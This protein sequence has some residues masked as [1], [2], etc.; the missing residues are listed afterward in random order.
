MRSLILLSS[1]ALLL[2]CTNG[3]SL[4]LDPDRGRLVEPGIT[5][6]LDKS[7]YRIGEIVTVRMTN[8]SPRDYGY[9]LCGRRYDRRVASGWVEM[10]EE[11]RMCTAHID[12]LPAGATRT[13]QTDLHSDATPGTYRLVVTFLATSG[14]GD[15]SRVVGVGPSFTIR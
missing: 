8:S 5:I 10:P 13:G 4:V 14:T 3:A 11:L 2:G 7:E 1:A 6:T 15:G 12:A 9:N